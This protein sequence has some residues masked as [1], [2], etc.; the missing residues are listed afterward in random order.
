MRKHRFIL[1]ALL[2]ALLM[3]AVCPALSVETDSIHGYRK[4][5]GYDYVAFGAYP[6]DADGTV[7]PI[8]WRV[9]RAADQEAYLLSEYILF[10]AP[11]HGDYEHYQGW[12]N[13]DLYQYLNQV[14]LSDAFTE[15]E[16]QAL[17]IRTEDNALVTLISAD[18]MKDASI[19]FSNNN[20]RL[21]ES[22]AYAKQLPDPP[23]FEL[24]ATNNRGKWKPLYIYSNG[25]K[26]SP[27]W[28]RTRSADYQHEQRRVMDEGKIGRISTGNSDLGV[29]PAVYVDLSLLSIAFGSGTKDSPYRLVY[30]PAQVIPAETEAPSAVPTEM[31]AATPEPE[32]NLPEHA[33]E[34][35]SEIP[36]PTLAP[37]P[38]PTAA[39]AHTADYVTYTAA[40][41][42]DT[43]HEKFPALTKEGFLPEGEAEFVY[44]DEKEGLWLYASQTLRIEINRRTGKNIN[45][46]ALRWYEAKVFLR[47]NS[48]VFDLYPYDA[49]NYTRYGDRYKALADKIATQHQLVFGINSDFFI[50]R[51]ERER[52]EKQ[53]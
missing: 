6:T 20:S 28:S 10:S 39:P 17:I 34:S 50:Y 18:E 5:G 24:P 33:T 44:A 11:V 8:L 21:C 31:P 27:W 12:E 29:R 37:T 45:K 38:E 49:A 46:E 16:Q 32:L 19:G 4:N 51:V 25:R 40:A 23:I 26:Y 47:D 14:F 43:I 30:K 9:L 22:T 2:T 35:P 7:Q 48:E 41:N 13:S 53:Q 52:E 15:E 3:S 1:F 42:P 36:E